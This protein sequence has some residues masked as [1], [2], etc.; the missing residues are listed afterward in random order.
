MQEM[1]RKRSLLIKGCV[2]LQVFIFVA[3][4]II[5][6]PFYETEDDNTMAGIALGLWGERDYHLVYTSVILGKII[7]SMAAAA[8]IVNW[9][10]LLQ[11]LMIFVAFTVI[12]TVLL[13]RGN[14][15]RTVFIAGLIGVTFNFQFYHS[16]QFTKTAAVVT[17]AGII[18]LVDVI[19]NDKKNIALVILGGLLLIVGSM[20]RFDSYG[21][22]LCTC[23][24]WVLYFFATHIK[25]KQFRKVKQYLLYFGLPI[26]LSLGLYIGD[27]LV[28]ETDAAWKEF[29]E[30]N[31]YRCDLLDYGFPDMDENRQLYESMS[32]TEY[33]YTNYVLWDFA[34]TEKL[35]TD[36]MGRLV[37][38][39]PSQ[40]IVPNIVNFWEEGYTHLL[41]MPFFVILFVAIVWFLMHKQKS[42]LQFGMLMA[43]FLCVET[44]FV[45]VG[46][47]QLAYTN[48]AIVLT[49]V[50]LLC[51]GT[52]E[53]TLIINHKLLKTGLGLAGCGIC[54][55]V[56]GIWFIQGI[57]KKYNQNQNADRDEVTSLIYED[58]ENIYFTKVGY[59]I[60]TFSDI[61]KSV[62]E[63]E[64]SNSA[65]LGDWLTMS[66]ITIEQL[67][68]Y[69]VSNPYRALSELDNAYLVD[70]LSA[71]WKHLY[72]KETYNDQARK[73]LVKNIGGYQIWEFVDEEIVL[74]VASSKKDTSELCYNGY[75][76]DVEGGQFVRGYLYEK[77][78]FS[79]EQRVYL[80]VIKEGEDTEV[81]Y[82][83]EQV[84]NTEST[85][86][87]NG[88]YSG[89][90]FWNEGIIDFEKDTVH[91]YLE[92]ENGLYQIKF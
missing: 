55:L 68:K 20:Y 45:C 50:V 12:F 74:D 42:I 76:L 66:P 51:Y 15:W 49:V 80:G 48:A 27:K 62:E 23:F 81:F 26:V 22:I 41:T 86:L 82:P 71:Y 30:Y 73:V 56:T 79:F 72:I 78:T 70:S 46:R 47:H 65:T 21:M 75:L 91:I 92:N 40:R 7:N 10:T 31:G 69:G 53:K 8:N 85:D 77:D 1:E 2:L 57:E 90:S 59:G 11:Y 14:I 37:D 34:D 19:E 84:R 29:S 43:G 24:L 17:L 35:T 64:A 89:F 32:L 63:G 5:T 44:F 33:G 54:V 39:K 38:G 60:E 87:Y 18:L 28:Y 83:A 36:V 58:K 67:E 9:Y 52:R 88:K 61:W 4:T 6:T 13:S 16:L 25:N 3:A